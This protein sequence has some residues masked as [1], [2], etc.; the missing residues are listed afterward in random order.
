MIHYPIYPR[1]PRDRPPPTPAEAGLKIGDVLIARIVAIPEIAMEA[2]LM[3]RAEN[4][5]L[6]FTITEKAPT[7]A[8]SWLKVKA[9]AK[10]LKAGR[11]L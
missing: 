8:F 3:S 6:V 9:K 10:I 2:R 1:C 7:R 5:P 11:P 4:D